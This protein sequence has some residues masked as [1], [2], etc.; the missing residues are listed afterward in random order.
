M[1]DRAEYHKQYRIK[2]KEKLNEYHRK[3]YHL[4]KNNNNNESK[5]ENNIKIIKIYII[6]LN[7]LRI[8]KTKIKLDNKFLYIINFYFLLSFFLWSL[9]RS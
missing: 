7:F 9:W 1:S 8:K 6:I 3:Y 4:N 5:K 2:N